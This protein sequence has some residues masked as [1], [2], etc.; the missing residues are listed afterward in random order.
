MLEKTTELKKWVESLF[1]SQE[2][3]GKLKKE[4][5]MQEKLLQFEQLKIEL[6]QG[7][8][9]ETVKSTKDLLKKTAIQI[10]E[11]LNQILK[12]EENLTSNKQYFTVH[13]NKLCNAIIMGFLKN[14]QEEWSVKTIPSGYSYEV[15]RDE[16]ADT[17]P[18]DFVILTDSKNKKEIILEFIPK[19]RKDDKIP[20]NYYKNIIDQTTGKEHSNAEGFPL[21]SFVT[22]DHLLNPSAKYYP[23]IKDKIWQLVEERILEIEKKQQEQKAEELEW[24]RIELNSFK[25]RLAEQEKLFKDKEQELLQEESASKSR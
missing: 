3:Y 8:T 17:R 14:K 23:I 9:E 10:N 2:K 20:E 24:K 5:A 16:Y 25:K 21:F 18:L 11:E 19:Y 12:L 1:E 7:G 13:L 22:K 15:G 4:K 6:N